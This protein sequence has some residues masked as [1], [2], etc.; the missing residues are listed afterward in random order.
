MTWTVRSALALQL[1]TLFE[2][3]NLSRGGW[4][5]GTRTP[6]LAFK[7]RCPTVRRSPKDRFVAAILPYIEFSPQFWPGLRKGKD[8]N[9]RA[10]YG[11]PVSASRLPHSE[12]W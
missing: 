12:Y 1:S 7:G 8:F 11:K 6:I 5:T 3:D 4:G 2:R 10:R 9:I